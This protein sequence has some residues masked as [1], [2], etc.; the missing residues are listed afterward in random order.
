MAV[1]ATT[2]SLLAAA[3]AGLPSTLWTAL[4]RL[5]TGLRRLGARLSPLA[6]RAGGF[7]TGPV[8]VVVLGRRPAVS[9]LVVAV[10]P[11][12]AAA[13]AWWVGSAVG[14]GTLV[15]LVGG[16]WDRT[17][18]ATAVCLVVGLLVALGDAS[19]A[20]NSGL[21]PTTVL[22]AGPVFG[23]A[24]TRY[25]TTVVEP[26]GP[27]VVSLPDALA[28]A[29]RVALVVGVPVGVCAFLLGATVRRLVGAVRGGPAGARAE[30]V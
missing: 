18:P 28:F 29:A 19:A 27:V 2:L 30:R 5:R 21:V 9:L 15:D 12:L 20:V 25:G 6:R 16:T 4:N 14:Y 3:A 13:T 17:D 26:W 1:L 22:V 24:A 23:A 10:A 7:L 8:R 11:V